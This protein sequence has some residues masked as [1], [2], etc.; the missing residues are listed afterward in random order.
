MDNK[1]IKDDFICPRS[2]YY[3]DF[4]PENLA[5]NANLQEFANRVSLIAGLHTG[6]K[7]STPD[8]YHQVKHLWHDLKR[9]K[10]HLQLN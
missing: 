8:A 4:S 1:R 2:S 6:G 10:K 3:G 5:F 9:S 7:M